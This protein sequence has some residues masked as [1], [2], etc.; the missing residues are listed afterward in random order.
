MAHNFTKR[1]DDPTKQGVVGSMFSGAKKGAAAGA[2]LGLGAR[3]ALR[4]DLGKAGL[5]KAAKNAMQGMDSAAKTNFAK[6]LNRGAGEGFW[7]KV[8]D[9]RRLGVNAQGNMIRGI[10]NLRSV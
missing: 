3:I 1:D 10:E 7:G 5:E 8:I 2:G 4:T 9:S 6:E